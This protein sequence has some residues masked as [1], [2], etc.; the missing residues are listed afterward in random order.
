MPKLWNAGQG[1]A[2]TE[3]NILEMRPVTVWSPITPSIAIAV[4]STSEDGSGMDAA[5]GQ[6]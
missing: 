3:S 1:G 2:R 6:T 5:T 4:S